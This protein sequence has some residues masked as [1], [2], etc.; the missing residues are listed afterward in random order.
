MI[1][2]D[3]FGKISDLFLQSSHLKFFFAQL[4]TSTRNAV[5]RRQARATRYVRLDHTVC[6]ITVGWRIENR[7][8]G[9]AGEPDWNHYRKKNSVEGRRVPNVLKLITDSD[10]RSVVLAQQI[11]CRIERFQTNP[12]P[13]FD[14]HYASLTRINRVLKQ[15]YSDQRASY[16]KFDNRS[17]IASAFFAAMLGGGSCGIACLLV[18]L[19]NRQCRVWLLCIFIALGA[20]L[21]GAAPIVSILVVYR[22][23]HANLG[24]LLSENVSAA[25]GIDASAP[26]YRRVENVS[27]LSIVVPK[28]KLRNV[29]RHV[30]RLN[31]QL[32]V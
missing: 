10:V 12:R 8:S 2:L 19:D 20:A 14:L 28:F 27:V 25:P 18:W 11:A 32:G 6:G 23:S 29:E 31:I 15:A 21:A 5:F 3:L 26:C 1:S 13:L 24:L 4:P 16:E 17:D 30:W 7:W 9:C 22:I